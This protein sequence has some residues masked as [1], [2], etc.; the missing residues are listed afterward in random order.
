MTIQTPEELA[1]LQR[2][3]K[4]VARVLDAMQRHAQPG[5]TTL[6]LD[7]YGRRLLE[8]AGARS[9]PELTYNFPGAT[10]ISVNEQLAHGV[11]G[12]YR[13]QHG[14]LVNVDVS[15][16]L[17][18]FFGDT[19]GSFVLGTPTDAQRRVC[20]GAKAALQAALDQVRTGAPLRGIGAAIERTARAHGLQ[21]VRNLGS[22][23]VGRALHEEP[24]FIPGFDDPRERRRLHEGQVITIEPFL[25]TGGR[26]AHDGDDGWTLYGEP[27]HIAAQYEHTLVVTRDGPLLMTVP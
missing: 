22:H 5:M 8:Q 3:G 17:D 11:P 26:W 27:G 25:S 14:D 16:E 12:S 6:S 7:Q 21:C 4:L 2:V 19:G 20:V 18:G 1:G 9:A 23:G 15:A 13:L 24:E 10:C